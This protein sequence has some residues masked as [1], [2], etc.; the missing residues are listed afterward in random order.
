MAVA[1]LE[2]S[3]IGFT[4]FCRTIDGFRLS[5][6]ELISSNYKGDIIISLGSAE[7]N[8]YVLAPPL[9]RLC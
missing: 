5:N 3:I 8:A 1:K 9:H 6:L 4:T 7:P 2:N